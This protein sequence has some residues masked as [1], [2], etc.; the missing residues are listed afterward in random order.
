MVVC[1][2]SVEVERRTV[3]VVRKVV[4]MDLLRCWLRLYGRSLP[5]AISTECG[6]IGLWFEWKWV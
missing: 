1:K 3:V 5:I 6:R 4:A 2:L